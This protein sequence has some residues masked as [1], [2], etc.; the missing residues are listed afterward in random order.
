[1]ARFILNK[2]KVFEQLDIIKGISDEVSYSFKSNTKVGQILEGNC[3]LSVHSKENLKLIENK[4]KV[5]FF[6]Q[7]NKEIPKEV[8][9]FVVDNE[10]DLKNLLK[11]DRTINLL[12]RLKLKEHTIHTGKHFVFGFSS[13]RI[14]ELLSELRNNKNIDKLGIHFHRKTQNVSEWNLKEELEDSIENFSNIDIVN[15]GGGIPAEYKNYR[16]EM[17]S[18]IFNKIKELKE[19]L[20]KKSIKVILEPG[21]F[22]A[23]PAIKLETEIINLYGNNIIVDASVYNAAMDTFVANIRLLVKD[24]VEK[25]EAYIIKGVTPDSLDIFRYRVYFEKKPEVGDKITFLNA[26]AYNYSSNFFNLK[27][28][29]TE[30]KD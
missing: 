14:N 21:R 26:G 22:I 1:M 3:S 16:K 7:G 20:N 25:G 4:E 23:G 15:I 2:K 12:L 5:W 30:I 17:I 28:I 27:E 18:H 8:N 10:N 11:E 19:F 13:S 9:N 24:E 29:E 6:L